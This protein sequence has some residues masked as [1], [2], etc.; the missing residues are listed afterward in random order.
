MAVDGLFD[1]ELANYL[2][3]NG[4][5]LRLPIRDPRELGKMNRDVLTYLRREEFP[6]GTWSKKKAALT[7]EEINQLYRKVENTPEVKQSV[8]GRYYGSPDYGFCQGRA[9]VVH[10]RAILDS[11][12]N[13]ES[14]RKI[15]AVGPM[16]NG[17]G[18]HVATLVRERSGEWY[19]I[20]PFF[21]RPLRVDQWYSELRMRFD[22]NHTLRLFVT[23]ASRFDVGRWY[24]YR[25]EP[26]SN[27][28]LYNFYADVMSR[29]FMEVT[30]KPGP[31]REVADQNKAAIQ[32]QK[33][34]RMLK[35]AAIGGA[36]AAGY[37]YLLDH[38]KRKAKVHNVQANGSENSF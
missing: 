26:M 2:E 34:V 16:S 21:E 13:K 20:D 7:L 23:P 5:L 25:K 10:H 28:R 14:I 30:G 32:A 3:S 24:K 1:G 8:C 35:K 33:M 22:R 17:W 4:N 38:S 15:W 31:W 19:A 9:L 37:G 12:L 29:I 11:Q 6:D 18:H 27:P 36:G